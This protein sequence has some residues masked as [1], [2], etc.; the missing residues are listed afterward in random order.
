MDV[1]ECDRWVFKLR[2]VDGL[3]CMATIDEGFRVCQINNVYTSH[4]HNV[5]CQSY[6]NKAAKF[7]RTPGTKMKKKEFKGLEPWNSLTLSDQK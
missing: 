4:L 7:E 6:L 2:E 3:T 5:V 1:Y